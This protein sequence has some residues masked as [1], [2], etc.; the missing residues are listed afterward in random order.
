MR[1]LHLSMVGLLIGCGAESTAPPAF[2]PEHRETIKQNLVKLGAKVTAETTDE[3]YV[4]LRNTHL[5]VREL[6]GII[7]GTV[8]TRRDVQD[9][10][11]ANEAVAIGFLE[12]SEF[13]EFKKWLE[14]SLAANAPSVLRSEYKEFKV[15]LSSK[16][17][18]T[19]F[20]RKAYAEQE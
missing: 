10:G 16:P 11:T 8:Q 14:K 12:A 15:T 5:Q 17:L 18:R 2:A 13:Q 6:G 20:T 19:V 3:L 4:S 1:W 7:E 9:F